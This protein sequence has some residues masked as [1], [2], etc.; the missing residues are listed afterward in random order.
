M[1]LPII[2]I[3]YALAISIISLVTQVVSVMPVIDN[4]PPPLRKHVNLK[5]K[6]LQKENER[7]E[8]I[9]KENLLLLKKLNCIMK[10]RNVDNYWNTPQP[11]YK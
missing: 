1:Y 4:H 10:T 3:K 11:K 2:K 8:K 7:C 5:L 6:Q 9:E